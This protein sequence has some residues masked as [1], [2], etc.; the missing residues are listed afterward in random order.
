MPDTLAD[1]ERDSVEVAGLMHDLSVHL[2][3]ALEREYNPSTPQYVWMTCDLREEVESMQGLLKMLSSV[4]LVA[5]T[6]QEG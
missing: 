1:S 3:N 2:W 6:G 5:S 4:Q